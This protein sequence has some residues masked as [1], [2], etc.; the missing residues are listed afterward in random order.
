[1]AGTAFKAAKNALSDIAANA[2]MPARMSSLF[3]TGLDSFPARC[4][5]PSS[6]VYSAF[7]MVKLSRTNFGFLTLVVFSA[8]GLGTALTCAFTGEVTVAVLTGALTATLVLAVL[9]GVKP[10][11]LTGKVRG[12]ATRFVATGLAAGSAGAV[13]ILAGIGVVVAVFAVT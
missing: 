10:V 7:G 8:L 4:L 5:R 12:F 2:L 9:S 13:A 1:M 6:T 11:A 3:F